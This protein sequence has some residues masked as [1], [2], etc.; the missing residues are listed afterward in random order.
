MTDDTEEDEEEPPSDTSSEESDDSDDVGVKYAAQER[1]RL[2]EVTHYSHSLVLALLYI[3]LNIDRSHIQL[4]K[5]V[6]F[7]NEGYISYPKRIKEILPKE[8]SNFRH[9]GLWIDNGQL[10]V[11]RRAMT[12]F[13]KL[14]LGCPVLPDLKLIVEEYI[15]DLCLPNDFKDF[16]FSLMDYYPCNFLDIVV[17]EPYLTKVPHYE[18]HCMIYIIWGLKLLFGL[19]CEY[20]LKL[21]KVVDKINN[22]KKHPKAYFDSPPNSTQRLFSFR[23]WCSYMQFRKVMLK[24]H[25]RY[26]NPSSSLDVDQYIGMEHHKEVEGQSKNLIEDIG[27]EIVNKIPGGELPIGIVPLNEF[28]PCTT[29]YS[30]YTRVIADHI[31]NPDVKLALTEDFTQ[32]SL[33][34]LTEDFFLTDPDERVSKNIA[35]GISDINKEVTNKDFIPVTQRFN[36]KM[37]YVKD[38]DNHNWTQT[39]PPTLHHLFKVES[40]TDEPVTDLS[41]TKIYTENGSLVLDSS[42]VNMVSNELQNEEL[43]KDEINCNKDENELKDKQEHNNTITE[44]DEGVNIFDDDFVGF[45]KTKTEIPDEE[46]DLNKTSDLI[47]D[48]DKTSGLDMHE[49]SENNHNTIQ[50]EI[51]ADRKSLSSIGSLDSIDFN[52]DTFDRERTIKELVLMRCKKY[53]IPIPKKYKPP[54]YCLYKPEKIP[55]RFTRRTVRGKRMRKDYLDNLLSEYYSH[56]E[57]DLIQQVVNSVNKAIQDVD[58]TKEN[59]NDIEEPN[60]ENKEAREVPPLDETMASNKADSPLQMEIDETILEEKEGKTN[61]GTSSESEDLFDEYS[62]GETY[63]AEFLPKKNPKFD[64]DKY[65]KKQLY[66]K[67]TEPEVPEMEIDTLK[68][69][70]DQKI[71]KDV[72][73]PSLLEWTKVK[74][75]SPVDSEDEMPLAEIKQQYD[76]YKKVFNQKAAPKQPFFRTKT[77]DQYKCW[78]SFYSA[79]KGPQTPR[80]T[81]MLAEL[82]KYFPKSFSFVL[83]TCSEMLE[84]DPFLLC[85]AL[86]NCEQYMLVKC[87]IKQRRRNRNDRFILNL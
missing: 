4:S 12:L 50:S 77:P 36:K 49:F 55:H 18:V 21:S 34:Y 60:K 29:P 37:V 76:I 79:F 62:D 83:V 63:G 82:K 42:D 64:E 72:K 43:E 19:D 7:S 84:F 3:A 11:G 14:N 47:N 59:I 6:R 22:R 17:N 54:A 61:H 8:L 85:G 86:Q 32:Y 51:P 87:K 78:F 20:E 53:K 45:D 44:E 24:K 26:F 58:Q 80:K 16:V 2:N 81:V 56:V 57:N 48:L 30:T 28:K 69:I 46:L 66:L 23:E 38:C 75:R 65:D 35:T 9:T 74:N 25:C 41:Q 39:Q 31:Q 68:N 15:Q 5:L 33:K 13:R 10:K 67:V 40:L 73:D 1:A 70:V 71:E 27:A 52:P